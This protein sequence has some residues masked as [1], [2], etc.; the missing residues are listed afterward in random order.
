[1]Y[2][3]PDKEEDLIEIDADDKGEIKVSYGYQEHVEAKG[4]E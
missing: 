2:T 3:T 4:M 1:M